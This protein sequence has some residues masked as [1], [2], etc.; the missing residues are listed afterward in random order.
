MIQFISVDPSL[1]VD[2]PGGIGETDWYSAQIQQF[3]HGKLR[4]ITGP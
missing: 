4:N 1:I 3:F 2:I